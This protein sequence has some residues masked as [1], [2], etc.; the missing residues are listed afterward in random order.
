MLLTN[1]TRQ[2]N[3]LLNFNIKSNNNRNLTL[4]ERM[5]NE[6]HLKKIENERNIFI[7]RLKAMNNREISN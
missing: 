4:K 5:K 6:N 2:D 1:D 7:E 3:G